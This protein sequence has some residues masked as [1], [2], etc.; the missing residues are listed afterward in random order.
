MGMIKMQ[1][2]QKPLS[3]ET[4]RPNYTTN[5]YNYCFLRYPEKSAFEGTNDL[6]IHSYAILHQ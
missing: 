1:I 5:N 3:V 6:I 2:T 4:I